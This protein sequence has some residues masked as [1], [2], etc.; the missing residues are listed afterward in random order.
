MIYRSNGEM[1]KKTEALTPKSST[2][3]AVEYLGFSTPIRT[4]STIEEGIK[5]FE[6][7]EERRRI[8]RE[9]PFAYKD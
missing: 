4:C 1:M 2:P 9:R 7:L 6:E 5:S 3:P 8:Q